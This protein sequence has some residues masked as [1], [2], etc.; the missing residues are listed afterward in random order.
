MAATGYVIIRDGK[1]V[2]TMAGADASDGYVGARTTKGRGYALDGVLLEEAGIKA[3]AA[4]DVQRDPSLARTRY[5]AYL[6]RPGV[7]TA[8]GAVALPMAEWAAQ[9]QAERDRH[10]AAA[11]AGDQRTGNNKYAGHCEHCGIWILPGYGIATYCGMDTGC[12]EHMHRAGWHLS[13]AD[14]ARCKERATAAVAA[15]REQR[16]ASAKIIIS[17]RGWGD[18]SPVAWQGDLRRADAEIL[19][20]MRHALTD[21]VANQGDVDHPNQSDE[22]LIGLIAQAR[23]ATSSGEIRC[24]YPQP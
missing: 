3:Q 16:M 10:L 24:Q 9:Q 2:L 15:E 5:E 4:A 14:Q 1:V 18:F 11:L 6:Y 7:P 20:E 17:S 13:C 21:A 8:S 12:P 23:G 19:A 22:Q